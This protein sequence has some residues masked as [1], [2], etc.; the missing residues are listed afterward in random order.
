L[1]AEAKTLVL[2]QSPATT[3]LQKPLLFPLVWICT[4]CLRVVIYHRWPF[5]Q[6]QGNA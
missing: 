1:L 6:K 3:Q 4:C 5:L 2:F